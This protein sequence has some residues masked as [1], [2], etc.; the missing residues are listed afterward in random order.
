MN[1]LKIFSNEEFGEIRTVEIDGKTEYEI[2]GTLVDRYGILALASAEKDK[3]K[4]WDYMNAASTLYHNQ[5]DF[6][7]NELYGAVAMHIAWKSSIEDSEFAIH[8]LFK[9]NYCK[10]R[11]GSVVN[12]KSD[13]KNIPD[14]WV[15]IGRELIPVEIKK[16]SFDKKA[17]N[18]L[19][20]YLNAYNCKN[21]IAVANKLTI[22]LPE[23][24][25]FISISELEG[26]NE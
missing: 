7:F 5:G 21:G 26:V 24:I 14:S 23:N 2:D 10:I 25:E 1:H 12:R 4:A 6:V 22:D 16:C 3:K 8:S 13:G 18:Q 11:K 15:Q 9:K 20:R 19:K 17:L